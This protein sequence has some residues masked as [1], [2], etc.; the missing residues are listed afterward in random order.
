MAQAVFYAK[1][2]A[3]YP[4]FTHMISICGNKEVSAFLDWA[5]TQLYA[6]HYPKERVW[7]FHIDHPHF[8]HLLS[9]LKEKI[10]QLEEWQDLPEMEKRA[11]LKSLLSPLECE[12][13]TINRLIG[14]KG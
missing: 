8:I 9:H 2:E 5:Y 10:G 12:E 1:Y 7:P 3:S 11:L 4:D 6:Y 13:E 14:L